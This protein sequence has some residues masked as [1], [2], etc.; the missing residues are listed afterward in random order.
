MYENSHSWRRRL[1]LQTLISI[2]KK[3]IESGK[4]FDE[5]CPKLEYKMQSKW[6]LVSN[7]R[8]EY[9]SSIRNMLENEHILAS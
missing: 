7:T 8:K 4:T 9:L 5:I 6:K 1:R 3:E 2:A